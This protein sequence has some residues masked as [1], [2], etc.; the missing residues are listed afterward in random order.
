ML[1]EYPQ[2]VLFLIA[3][4]A[5]ANFEAF[6]ATDFNNQPHSVRL[7][8]FVP[9]T[10]NE[11]IFTPVESMTQALRQHG[12]VISIRRNGKIEYLVSEAFTR[13]VLTDESSF[14]FEHGIS[15]FLHL[16]TVFRLHGGTFFRDMDFI[17]KDYLGPS[18]EKM[19]QKI[20]SIFNSSSSALAKSCPTTP[21]DV[22]PLIQKTMA[23][24]TISIFFGSDYESEENIHRV[25]HIAEDI[26]DFMGLFQNQSK[27]VRFSPILWRIYTW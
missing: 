22:L 7:P 3:C 18:K 25:I 14:S 8:P 23:E 1:L 4:A 27:L 26:A 19:I 15:K 10:R 12:P 11:I 24:A 17:L 9:L 16:H 5:I 20:W 2:V 21:I 13:R 6:I